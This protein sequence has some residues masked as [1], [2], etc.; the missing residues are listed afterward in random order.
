MKDVLFWA[1]GITEF[2]IWMES[3]SDDQVIHVTL[4]WHLGKGN[5]DAVTGSFCI[6]GKRLAM[7]T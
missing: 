7:P 2:G 3:H 4:R 6:G 1:I 5:L